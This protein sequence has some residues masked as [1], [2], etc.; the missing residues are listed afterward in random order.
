MSCVCHIGLA[1]MMWRKY[2]SILSR[3]SFSMMASECNQFANL[4]R[5]RKRATHKRRWKRVKGILYDIPFSP[6]WLMHE[7]V[8]IHTCSVCQC[9]HSHIPLLSVVF[10][11]FAGNSIWCCACVRLPHFYRISFTLSSKF[12][13]HTFTC[14]AI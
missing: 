5:D 9:N 4:A 3:M 7:L 12:R 8:S 10:S 1:L 14:I 11:Y 2:N 13:L 6:V